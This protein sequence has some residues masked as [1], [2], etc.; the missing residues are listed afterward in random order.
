[1]QDREASWSSHMAGVKQSQNVFVPHPTGRWFY[2]SCD[3]VNTNCSF[4]HVVSSGAETWRVDV[5]RCA[6]PLVSARGDG[7]KSLSNKANTPV[8]AGLA[9]SAPGGR[10]VTCRSYTEASGHTSSA[11]GGLSKTRRNGVYEKRSQSAMQSAEGPTSW[12][13]HWPGHK[14]A[15][16]LARE[17]LKSK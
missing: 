5:L 14:K 13:C 1:M 6:S 12:P 4:S 15:L 10:C 17:G 16:T 7:E 3:T 9:A 8:P 11:D 2:E